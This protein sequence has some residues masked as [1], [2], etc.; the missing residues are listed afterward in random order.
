MTE[1]RDELI[2]LIEGLPDDKIDVLLARARGLAAKK[3]KGAWPPRFVG[4]I[5]DGPTDG[6]TTAPFRGVS[7]SW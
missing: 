3:R 6:S 7:K 1:S 2:H 5:K 4:M